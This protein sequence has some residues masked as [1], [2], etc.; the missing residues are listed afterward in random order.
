MSSSRTALW[1]IFICGGLS[2]RVRFAPG[3]S[4]SSSWARTSRASLADERL[5]RLVDYQQAQRAGGRPSLLGLEEQV[6][7]GFPLRRGSIHCASFSRALVLRTR[8]VRASLP[9][10][11]PR[12][13]LTIAVITARKGGKLPSDTCACVP[14]MAWA[15]SSEV[16]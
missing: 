13:M 15:I 12:N 16:P 5:V 7:A 3:D 10:A 9:P 2:D 6:V 11:A 1:V 8:W 4:G 14:A